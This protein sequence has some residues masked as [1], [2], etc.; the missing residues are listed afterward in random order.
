MDEVLSRGLDGALIE[1][2][3]GQGGAGGSGS[4]IGRV[5]LRGG[6]GLGGG[7]LC[8][9]GLCCGRRGVLCLGGGRGGSRLRW[10]REWVSV[11]E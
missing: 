10:V 3:E 11:V 7:G 4:R 1:G 6:G 9:G 2:R 5:C 8:G